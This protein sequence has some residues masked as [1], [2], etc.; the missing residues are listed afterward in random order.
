MSVDLRAHRAIDDLRSQVSLQDV[1]RALDQ[2]MAGKRR[3]RLARPTLVLAAVAVMATVGWV[4]AGS[5]TQSST[6]AP[7]A[8]Q[9]RSAEIGEG[10][11]GPATMR[12]PA[13]W[14]IAHDGRYVELT[15]QDG[16]D[17]RLVITIAYEVYEPPAYD[18]TPIQEDLL[19]WLL[20][21][22]AIQLR[23]I[24]RASTSTKI[25]EPRGCVPGPATRWTSR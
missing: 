8:D 19:V 12:L 2:A 11:P 17:A 21:H 10:L 23:L 1:E 3:G 13:G 7:P 18:R 15:P 22:P 20:K 4:I 9:P 6:P 16:S 14:D 25:R 24:D 5:V